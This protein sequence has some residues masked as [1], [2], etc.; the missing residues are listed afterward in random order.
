MLFPSS[1]VKAGKEECF[2]TETGFEFTDRFSN[3]NRNLQTLFTL[4]KKVAT[5]FAIQHKL[6][7]LYASCNNGREE[8]DHCEE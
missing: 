2:P 4:F 5:D 3:S 8:W 1:L 6:I 7:C